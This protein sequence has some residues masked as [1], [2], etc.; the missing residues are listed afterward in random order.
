MKGEQNVLICEKC[1]AVYDT[2][3]KIRICLARK[4]GKDCKGK[5]IPI[6]INRKEVETLAKEEIVLDGGGW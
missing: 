6:I 5:L 2:S 1:S 4:D 3:F